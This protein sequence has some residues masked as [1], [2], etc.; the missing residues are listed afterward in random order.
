MRRSGRPAS[1]VGSPFLLLRLSAVRRLKIERESLV[2]PPVHL[3]C[4]RRKGTL[5]G[6]DSRRSVRHQ[7]AD[8]VNPLVVAHLPRQ[9]LLLR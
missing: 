5:R 4:K 6:F 2:W 7:A 8:E 3:S 9:R 1:P